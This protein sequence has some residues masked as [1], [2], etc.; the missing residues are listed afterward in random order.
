MRFQLRS[1]LC[2]RGSSSASLD[3]SS[4]LAS[5][6]AAR[7]SSCRFGA[8]PCRTPG[9]PYNNAEVQQILKLQRWVGWMLCTSI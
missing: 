9:G 8:V 6:F 3:T 2:N 7:L 1:R 5:R 4:Q